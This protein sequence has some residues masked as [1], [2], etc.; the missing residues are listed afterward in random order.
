MTE[1]HNGFEALNSRPGNIRLAWVRR[2]SR[3][4]RHRHELRGIRDRIQ[5][6][7]VAHNLYAPRLR[8]CMNSGLVVN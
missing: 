4:E 8:L 1:L 5:E 2:K 3:A 7:L 6:L